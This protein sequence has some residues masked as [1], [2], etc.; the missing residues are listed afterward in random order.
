MDYVSKNWYNFEK[1]N[2]EILEDTRKV[3]NLVKH[4]DRKKFASKIKDY[5]YKAIL[6]AMFD[7]KNVFDII[8][9]LL[10]PKKL[11]HPV[12]KT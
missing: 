4:L 10:K 8:A 9:K 11:N 6:F 7:N 1:Q 3:F 2:L 5:Q 12:F